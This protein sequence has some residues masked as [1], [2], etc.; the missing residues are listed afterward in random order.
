MSEKEEDLN[1]AISGQIMS[2]WIPYGALRRFIF[3]FLLLISVTRFF[4]DDTFYG[5]VTLFLASIM[6]PRV[7]GEVLYFFGRIA[8]LIFR[9][10]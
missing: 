2:T 3:A 7:V 8:G 6:S 5:F 4:N 10:K 1:S 9:G